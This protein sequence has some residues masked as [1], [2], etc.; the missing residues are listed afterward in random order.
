VR[1]GSQSS[2]GWIVVKNWGMMSAK[3][4]RSLLASTHN[5]EAVLKITGGVVRSHKWCRHLGM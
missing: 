3:V 2:V 5:M 4:M 1:V